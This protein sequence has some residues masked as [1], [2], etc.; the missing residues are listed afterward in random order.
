[1]WKLIKSTILQLDYQMSNWR[2][3]YYDNDVNYNFRW[4]NLFCKM[5]SLKN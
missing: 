2:I 3:D 1:M 4:S 5:L